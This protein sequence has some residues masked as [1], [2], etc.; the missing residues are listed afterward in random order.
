[1]E[2]DNTT[3]ANSEPVDVIQATSA[4]DGVTSVSSMAVPGSGTGVDEASP[5]TSEIV[6]ETSSDI[7][8]VAEQPASVSRGTKRSADAPADPTTVSTN[9]FY[10]K[11]SSSKRQRRIPSRYQN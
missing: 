4:E 9:S 11:A 5:V 10:G 1:M 7:I 8:N 3:T 6:N 2:E